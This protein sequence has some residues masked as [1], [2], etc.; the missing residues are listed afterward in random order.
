MRGGA[1]I[2]TPISYQRVLE[3]GW[4]RWYLFIFSTFSFM[5]VVRHHTSHKRIT[6]F[7][8]GDE[9]DPGWGVGGGCSYVPCKAFR[10]GEGKR[11]GYL[12]SK[13]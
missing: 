11:R 2:Y 4:L 3:T 8:D 6:G 5:R 9:L 7:K 1:E 10:A 13:S 12:G